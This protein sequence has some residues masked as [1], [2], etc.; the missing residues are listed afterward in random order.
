[1]RDIPGSKLKEIKTIAYFNSTIDAIYSLLTDVNTHSKFQ[2]G[3]LT[4]KP[5]GKRLN[6]EQYFYQELYMPWPFTNRDGVFKQI[7]NPKSNY[8]E[9]KIETK[10][11]A[12]FIPKNENY[13]RVPFLNSSWDIKK[14]NENQIV[15]EYHL[16]VDPGGAV[17]NWL[18]NLFIDRGPY[19]SILNMRKLLKEEVYKNATINWLHKDI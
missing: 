18:V 3:C 14:I 17:P 4:S 6:N 10:S 19:E 1:V 13:V 9:L 8:K 16:R 11:Q 5:I 12:E 15:G 2:F 7:V